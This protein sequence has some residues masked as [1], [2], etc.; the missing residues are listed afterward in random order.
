M[1]QVMYHQTSIIFTII[2]HIIFIIPKKANADKC[3]DYCAIS[4][5]SHAIKLPTKII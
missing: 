1:K 5:T 3:E 2:A 4:L